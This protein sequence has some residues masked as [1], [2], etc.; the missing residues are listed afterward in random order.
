MVWL[1]QWKDSSY[2]NKELYSHTSINLY[3]LYTTC[4][5]AQHACYWSVASDQFVI[6]YYFRETSLQ[7]GLWDQIRVDHGKE[8]YLLLFMQEKL[9]HFRTNTNTT[10]R[11]VYSAW[12]YTV[13]DGIQCMMEPLYNEH[14]WGTMFWPLLQRLFCTQTDLWDKLIFGTYLGACHYIYIT[15]LAFIQGSEGSGSEGFHIIIIITLLLYTGAFRNQ[16]S[17]LFLWTWLL[18]F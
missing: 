4:M 2:A 6:L 18:G 12:W 5:H 17:L 3:I 11:Q 16:Y 15:Q 7:H 9:A 10:S 1:V 8:F 13:H 14:L